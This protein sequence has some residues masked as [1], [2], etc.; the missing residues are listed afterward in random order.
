MHKL[1]KP[2]WFKEDRSFNP[3]LTQCHKCGGIAHMKR[4][5]TG[6]P[7]MFNVVI[8]PEFKSPCERVSNLA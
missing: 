7:G 5:C 2:I 3:F 6:T 4:D 8:P 1:Q